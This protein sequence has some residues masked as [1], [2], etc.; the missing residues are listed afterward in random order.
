M[1]GRDVGLSF[2]RAPG[3]PPAPA[4]FT[5]ERA[6]A[7]EDLYKRGNDQK[8]REQVDARLAA[9][10]SGEN[11][12]NDRLDE[13][14]E[15][16]K[17]IRHLLEGRASDKNDNGLK[18]DIQDLSRGLNQLRAIMAPD[19]L[20]NGGIINRLK[21]VE[22]SSGIEEKSI[23]S[24]WKFWTT[25]MVAAAGFLT[26]ALT[27]LDKI[28]PFFKNIESRWAPPAPPAKPKKAVRRRRPAKA[29][30]PQEVPD[31]PAREEVPE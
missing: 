7:N 30:A 14:D 22:R 26:A 10:T 25:L 29:A 9:L 28:Q 1:G 21:A 4:Y 15:E 24:R 5:S 13:I 2:G 20:G 3:G 27:N 31:A 11:D 6:M 18:G 19:S 12:Q 16:L 8:W 17:E 23:E